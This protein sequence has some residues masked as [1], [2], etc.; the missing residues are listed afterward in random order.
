M[1]SQQKNI[2]QNDRTETESQN[3]SALWSWIRQDEGKGNITYR[4]ILNKIR[5]ADIWEKEPEFFD[6]SVPLKDGSVSAFSF[7][8]SE[9]LDS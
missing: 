6:V 7:R 8:K 4:I 2:L 1:A 3:A 5:L 9:V